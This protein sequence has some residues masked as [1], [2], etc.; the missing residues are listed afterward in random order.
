MTMVLAHQPVPRSP[1]PTIL[2]LTA[3]AIVAA[4]AQG[5]AGSITGIP[6]ASLTSTSQVGLPM[7]NHDPTPDGINN[8]TPG[9]IRYFIPLE[10][11]TSGTYGIN[12]RGMTSDTGNGP[13]YLFMNLMFTPTAPAPLQK[14][15]LEFTFS[16]LDLRYVN[17]PAG[18]LETVRVYAKDG[19]TVEPIS[20]HFTSAASTV[21]SGVY[22]GV[23]WEMSRRAGSAGASWPVHLNLWGDGLEALMTDPF[24]VQLK[25]T[26]PSGVPYGRNTSEYVR[27]VLTTESVP[28]PPPAPVPEPTSMLLMGAGLGAAALRRRGLLKK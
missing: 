1:L 12:G 6:V 20:P 10:N 16:D 2:L 14:A 8:A 26:V 13:G 21:S 17:D 28:P 27:A 23:N 18:F 9:W 5:L 24:W 22:D 4:P 3:A 7:V 15:L 25:F 11:A 19:S